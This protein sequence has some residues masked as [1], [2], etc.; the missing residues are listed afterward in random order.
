MIPARYRVDRS[1]PGADQYPLPA[2]HQILEFLLDRLHG[3][4]FLIHIDQDAGAEGNQHAENHRK[5]RDELR[6]FWLRKPSTN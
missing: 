1:C 5:I 6:P 4:A 2:S 3:G